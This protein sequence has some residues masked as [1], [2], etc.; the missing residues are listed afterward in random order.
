MAAAWTA[1]GLAG[2]AAAMWSARALGALPAPRPAWDMDQAIISHQA[3][4]A[5]ASPPARVVLLGDSSCLMDVDARALGEGVL[6]LATLSY[7]GLDGQ[8]AMLEAYAARHETAPEMVVL[9]MNPESLRRAASE[10]G[11]VGLLEACLA[12]RDL[13]PGGAAVPRLPGWLGLELVKT[14]LLSGWLPRPLPPSFREAYGTTRGVVRAMDAQQGSLVQPGQYVPAR[15][16]GD[17][18]YRWP[19]GLEAAAERFR[20]A[21]PAGARFAAGLT[22]VPAA[23]ARA[24][25]PRRRRELLEAFAAHLRPDHLLDDLPATAPDAHFGTLTHLNETG[26]AAFTRQLSSCL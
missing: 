25:H 11:F 21:V 12:G 18:A 5:V 20:A 9:L 1:G 3:R 14:R 22:P 8:A 15:N 23:H 17:A 7:L 13:P 16:D 10:P 4:A 2:F 26:R 24:D 6:N 19:D